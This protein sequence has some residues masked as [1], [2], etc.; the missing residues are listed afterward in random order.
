MTTDLDGIEKQLIRIADA[1]E[2]LA[3]GGKSWAPNY[4]RRLEEYS[5]F[6]WENIGAVIEASDS[7][8]ATHVNW[9]GQTFIRR[10]GPDKFGQAIWF[11]RSVGKDDEGNTQYVRL[12]TFRKI[13][14]AEPLGGK[15]AEELAHSKH[16]SK[17]SDNGRSNPPAPSSA[18]N[19][20]KPE[21]K[22]AENPAPAPAVESVNASKYYEAALGKKYNLPREYAQRIA[23]HVGIDVTAKNPDFTLAYRLLPWYAEAKAYGLDFDAA[24]SIMDERQGNLAK[25]TEVL[26][27]QYSGPQ[28]K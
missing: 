18:G 15:V 5:N 27:K 26:R 21:E 2:R 6:D 10:T 14:E 16:N 19:G 9:E 11:S 8:G 28:G 24:M 12:I 7:S 3:S 23:R 17:T 13:S 1:L 25:A 22:P 4:T 20:G